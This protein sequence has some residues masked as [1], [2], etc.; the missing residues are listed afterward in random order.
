MTKYKKAILD[1][2]NT[3]YNHMTADDVYIKMKQI[4]PKIVLASI[5]N[6]LNSL[7]DEDLIKRIVIEG[8]DNRYDKMMKHDHLVCKKCGKLIDINFNDYTK[9]LIKQSGIDILGYDLKVYIICSECKKEI[10]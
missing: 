6:N 10:K 3:S 7:V 1:I 8:E 5:Y 9:E 4:Y 2:I